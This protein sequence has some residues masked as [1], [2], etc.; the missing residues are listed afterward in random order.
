[1]K[2][3]ICILYIDDDPSNLVTFKAN[4]RKFFDIY[5]ATSAEEGMNILDEV[6]IPVVIADQK[7]PGTTGIQFFQHLSDNTSHKPIKIIL[8]G[9]ADLSSAID[10]I[11]KGQVYKYIQKPWDENEI[12]LAI[13][14]GAILY[15]ETIEKERALGEL[16]DK[17][18]KDLKAPLTA[19]AGVV[20]LAKKDSRDLF[21]VK[22]Y[23]NFMSESIGSINYKLK[24]I[25]EGQ[26]ENK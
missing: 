4:F 9:Y 24:N 16:V 10:A 5:T 19:L 21:F 17:V 6:E 12:R 14:D 3:R 15:E 26:N 2:K 1:M 18:N 23:L 7:M 20:D 25:V 13:K 8:T 11:N 22:S